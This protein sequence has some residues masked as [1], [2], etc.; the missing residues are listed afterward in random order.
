MLSFDMFR[1]ETSA[2]KFGL[3]F[4]IIGPLAIL[5]FMLIAGR[6]D[7]LRWLYGFAGVLSASLIL[8][9]ILG[10]YRIPVIPYFIRICLAA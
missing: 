4:S 1:K 8:I 6:Y 9:H 5:G 3:D 2:L 7:G 10:R